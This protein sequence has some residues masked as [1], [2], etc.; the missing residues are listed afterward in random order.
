MPSCQPGDQLVTPS[1]SADDAPVFGLVWDHPEAFN[2]ASGLA[3]P[4][5][6]RPLCPQF[7]TS[8]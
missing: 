7:N 2:Y 1:T 5:R 8:S 6:P 3:N 4:K